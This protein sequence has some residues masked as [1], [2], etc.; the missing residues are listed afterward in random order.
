[1]NAFAANS[2]SDESEDDQDDF[3]HPSADPGADEFADYN[4]RKRRRTGRDS[5]ESAALGIFGSE[6]EDE[7]PNK[8]WKNKNRSMRTKGMSFVKSGQKPS[9]E[10]DEDDDEESEDDSRPVLGQSKMTEDTNMKGG[11]DGDMEEDERPRMGLGASKTGG[12]GLG[13]REPA[14]QSPAMRRVGLGTTNASPLGRGFV[15][16]SAAAPVLQVSDDEQPPPRVALPSAFSTPTASKHGKGQKGTP[17]VGGSFASRMMAKMGYKEG[18][19]LGKDGQGRSGVIEVQLRPSGVGLGAVKEKSKQEKEEERRQASIRGAVLEDSEEEERK[20]RRRKAKTSGTDSGMSTPKRRPKTKYQS[21]PEL[22][23]AAP[24]LHIPEAFTP[25]LDMTGPAQKLLTSTSGLLTP[26]T[27][28][29]S[30][31]LIEAKKVARR[32]QSDLSAFVE[33]WKNLEERKAWVE[34]E[35]LQQQQLIDEQKSVSDQMSAVAEIVQGLAETVR[36]GQWDPVIAALEKVEE[37]G[38]AGNDEL[39]SIA[40]AAVHPF[41]RQA[42]EGWQPLEDPK[43]KTVASGGFAPALFSI[44]DLLGMTSTETN[45]N[46]LISH[47]HLSNGSAHGRTH[48][49]RPY[50]SMMYTV[51]FPKV[52]SAITNT[53]DV[54]DPAPLQAL[55]EAWEGLIPS[56]IH[57]QIL[58]KLVVPKLEEAV[59]AWNPKKKRHVSPPHLWLFPWLQFLAAHHADPKSSTGLVSDVKRKFRHLID[60]WDFHRGVVPGL[61]QW[62]SV[63][64]PHGQNDQWKPLIRNHVLPNLANY[65]RK[66]FQ[67]A[68]QDQEPFMSYLNNTLLWKDI[69]GLR[70]MGQLLVDVMFPMWHNVLHQWLTLDEANYLEIGEWLDFW[71]SIIPDDLNTVPAVKAEWQRGSDM[72]NLALDLG[73]NAKSRLPAPV[74]PGK[75]QEPVSKKD[76][77]LS[78]PAKP[79]A[80]AVEFSFRHQVEDW[81]VAN[82]LQFIPEKN[83]LEAG[84]PVYRVT[85]APIGKGGV[86]IYLRGDAIFAQIKRGEWTPL[87]KEMD[88]LL[89]MA[90]R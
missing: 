81:C 89:A 12:L 77:P 16:S 35:I 60:V 67:V 69:L 84:G 21:L 72:I 41:F 52:R 10:D 75:I 82:D 23:K 56:F 5:K 50:E 15:P 62:Q 53:W 43:L 47:V 37:L 49:T 3:L 55:L 34:M 24:G 19:G 4:P 59:A 68:P 40:V 57:S 46:A 38:I 30:T 64:R 14:W 85:A 25:I 79:A 18:Q 27:G 74:E 88:A 39:A 80:E 76:K 11:E 7:G 29:E 86:L 13:A 63:L 44:R 61:Q 32:A 2:S 1:M 33:E 42:T 58:E 87:G 36:D 70:D 78:P 17:T 31:E 8:R 26:T 73:P 51:W 83:T 22:Q 28:M 54:Y 66:N 6:S 90:Y 48:R 71:R 45:G 65:L 9:D 20:R